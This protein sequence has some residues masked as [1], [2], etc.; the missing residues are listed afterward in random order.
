[1]A[2]HTKRKE[3]EPVNNRQDNYPIDQQVGEQIRTLIPDIARAG[4]GFLLRAVRYMAGER[5]IRG[6]RDR[7]ANREGL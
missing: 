6:R 5:L 2:D 7:S 3:N 4:R 1:M